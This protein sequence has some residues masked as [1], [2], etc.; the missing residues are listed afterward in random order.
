[1]KLQTPN[2]SK[3]AK[4]TKY[5][6]RMVAAAETYMGLVEVGVGLLPGAGGCKEIVRRVVSPA[7]QMASGCFSERSGAFQTT[8]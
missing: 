3:E 7:M 5:F 1:M 6:L 8:A 2:S 4:E